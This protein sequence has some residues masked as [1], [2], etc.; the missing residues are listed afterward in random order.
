M[1]PHATGA[2]GGQ[3]PSPAAVQRAVRLICSS[4]Q[5]AALHFALAVLAGG[6]QAV[7]WVHALLHADCPADVGAPQDVCEWGPAGL[8][9]P[10]GDGMLYSLTRSCT[11]CS[12]VA[13]PSAASIP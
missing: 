7:P 6:P 4:Q 8:L 1:L 12:P 9:T 5:A 3:L 10:A 13:P 2:A 11:A